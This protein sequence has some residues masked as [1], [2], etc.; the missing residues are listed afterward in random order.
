M[1]L[2]VPRLGGDG[3]EASADTVDELVLVNALEGALF[4]FL[5]QAG[6]S[7]GALA[8]GFDRLGPGT[9]GLELGQ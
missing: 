5:V 8:A 9:V 2:G 1:I 6:A 7:V 4:F 3:K